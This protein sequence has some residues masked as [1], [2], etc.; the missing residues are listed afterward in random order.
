MYYHGVINGLVDKKLL[1][2]L[3][4]KEI[5]SA[6]RMGIN[7]QNGFN[8]GNFIS[9]CKNLGE[10]VYSKYPNNNAFKKYIVDNFCFVIGEDIKTEEVVFIP[11]AKNMSA[12]DLFNL[13]RN[14]PDKRFS[15]L[16]DEYQAIDHIPLSD[17]VAIGIPYDREVVDGY[18]KLSP[19]CILTIEEFNSLVKQVESIAQNLNI[20]VVNSSTYESLNELE[21]SKSK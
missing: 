14:N 21:R 12:I 15:D 10:E 19:F 17:V 18:I 2:I 20:K 9:I 4:K 5:S 6:S 3:S 8:E 7:K 11:N 13:R 1:G 16:V